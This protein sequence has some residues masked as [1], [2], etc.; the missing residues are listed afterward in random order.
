MVEK[1]NTVMLGNDYACIYKRYLKEAVSVGG[2]D[3]KILKADAS[4]EFH[5]IPS[6]GCFCLLPYGIGPLLLG[7][8]TCIEIQQVLVDTANAFF[9]KETYPFLEFVQGDLRD[10]KYG[11]K[12][13]DAVIDLSTLDHMKFDEGLHVIDEYARVL[14]ANGD[15]V[16]V[17]WCR[18]KPNSKTEAGGVF[19]Y[20]EEEVTRKINE[21][22]VIEHKET[23]FIEN[24]ESPPG[25]LVL[26]RGKRKYVGTPS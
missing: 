26:W 21:H 6:S 13:F 1:G 19:Y 4:N 14:K 3:K 16:L 12:Y 20:D 17:I 7:K 8:V 15:L 24:R 2:I 23:I 25:L 11:D 18:A 9:N 10:I 22:F 5:G